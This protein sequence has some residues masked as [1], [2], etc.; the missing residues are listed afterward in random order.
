[1]SL[2]FQTEWKYS[3]ITLC[4]SVI[5]IIGTVLLLTIKKLYFTPA[6]DT[7]SIHPPL[8]LFAIGEMIC[9]LLSYLFALLTAGIF[10]T[11]SMFHQVFYGLFVFWLII[12]LMCSYLFLVYRFYYTFLDSMFAMKRRSFYFH[13]FVVIS[14]PTYLVF[15][16]YFYYVQLYSFL[17]ISVIF[18]LGLTL[19]AYSSLI[20]GFNHNL[21]KL[22]LKHRQETSSIINRY[23]NRN[24]P[25][26]KGQALESSSLN[27][28]QIFM[29]EQITKQTLLGS[30]HVGC[31]LCIV[32]ICLAFYVI[33]IALPTNHGIDLFKNSKNS[34]KV[35][36]YFMIIF[37]WSVSITIIMGVVCVY[38]GFIF[39][40]NIY[41]FIC[42]RVHLKCQ[43]FC[44]NMA[45]KRIE[46]LEIM[47]RLESEKTITTTTASMHSMRRLESAQHSHRESKFEFDID[48]PMDAI[49]AVDLVPC[50]STPG[51]T[52]FCELQLGDN[53]SVNT[54]D[55]STVRNSMDNDGYYG[56]NKLGLRLETPN[57]VE[58]S[59]D[60]GYNMEMTMD[61]DVIVD[62]DEDFEELSGSEEV[63]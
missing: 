61:I 12:G 25:S 38:L 31:I 5:S 23:Q 49:D 46:K 57:S 62:E 56:Q 14:I 53:I 24:R 26:L 44:E 30:F 10:Q 15:A 2:V 63:P 32:L 34:E 7:L 16:L 47:E 8:K 39:N 48:T 59:V 36:L 28:H 58:I 43:G 33:T 11:E 21:F 22:V 40:A 13:T 9:Y 54:P 4:S 41:Q 17:V 6:N 42:G 35:D 52:T 3:V 20:Y 55:V 19:I 18:G 27:T 45:E 29:I 1:M 60:D 50:V 51:T 37:S